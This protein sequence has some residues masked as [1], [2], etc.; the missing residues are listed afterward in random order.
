MT[1]KTGIISLTPELLEELGKI[2]RPR[3]EELNA[4]W[5]REGPAAIE[6]FAATG[7]TMD[8]IGGNCPVQAE[9][10]VD[11]KAF[12]FRA[13]GSRWT[14]TVAPTQ[15][16]MFDAPVYHLE[17]P[18]GEGPYDA[19]WMPRHEALGFITAAIERYREQGK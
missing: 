15:A 6:A 14:F 8:T 1:D 7:A 10:T 3:L 2:I 5:E 12:Y 17:Q 13:R 9:G 18:Y 4:E 19:G 11:G 16:E